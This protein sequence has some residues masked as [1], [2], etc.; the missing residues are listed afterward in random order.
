MDPKDWEK[1]EKDVEDADIEGDLEKR[2]DK[3][4]EEDLEALKESA[5]WARGVMMSSPEEV[6]TKSEILAATLR[7]EYYLKEIL[8]ELKKNNES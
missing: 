4:L 3:Q 1:F 8:K 7:N 6:S 5:A 2:Y